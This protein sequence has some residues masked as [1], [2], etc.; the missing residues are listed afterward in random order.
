MFGKPSKKY[1][2]VSKIPIGLKWVFKINNDVSYKDILV[3][4][5]FLKVPGV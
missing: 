2:P 1:L 3:A 5:C 4:L